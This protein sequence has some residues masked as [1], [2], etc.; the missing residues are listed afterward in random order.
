MGPVAHGEREGWDFGSGKPRACSMHIE[1]GASFLLRHVMV[2][3]EICAAARCTR[4]TQSIAVSSTIY[5]YMPGAFLLCEDTHLASPVLLGYLRRTA[6]IHIWR[7]VELG[8]KLSPATCAVPKRVTDV[9]RER[10]FG[11]ISAPCALAAPRH[12]L[13]VYTHNQQRAASPYGK[14]PQEDASHGGDSW[15]DVGLRAGVLTA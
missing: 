1:G 11:P 15:Q 8:L 14:L 3:L 6:F 7:T 13:N 12:V 5:K 4:H 9:V 2:K 10:G